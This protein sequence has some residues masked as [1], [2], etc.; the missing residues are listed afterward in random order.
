VGTVAKMKIELRI[1]LELL[2]KPQKAAF[3]LA[4]DDKKIKY[5]IHFGKISLRL[6]TNRITSIG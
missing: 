5:L 2:S 3:L 6:Q 4:I 1:T